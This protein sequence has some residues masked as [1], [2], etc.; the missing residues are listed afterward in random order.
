MVGVEDCRSW[1]SRRSELERSLRP[2]SGS[3]DLTLGNDNVPS[4][5]VKV[6]DGGGVGEQPPLEE[7]SSRK[8]ECK[9]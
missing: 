9:M 2:E 8:W 5:I 4:V 6:S 1:E 3:L 7:S